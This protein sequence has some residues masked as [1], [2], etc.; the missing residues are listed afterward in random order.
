MQTLNNK[1]LLQKFFENINNDTYT[2]YIEIYIL[3]SHYNDS[4]NNVN[5]RENTLIKRNLDNDTF[6]QFMDKFKSNTSCKLFSKSTVKI[7][8]DNMI[9]N[10]S[11]SKSS[12][13]NNNVQEEI[14]Y[15]YDIQ[16]VQFLHFHDFTCIC[17]AYKKI[18]LPP[19]M[20]PSTNK[21]NDILYTQ[22]FSTKI[23]NLL[24]LNFEITT[25][26]TNDKNNKFIY[27]NYNHDKHTDI[28]NTLELLYSN[29]I[30]LQ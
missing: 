26:D 20:F 3:P 30:N 28:S 24:Y 22:R 14:V 19:H 16:N 23:N 18:I 6:S 12:T 27:F 1:T 10:K 25:N 15:I 8:H 4:N 13:S 9:L 11:S 7:Y 29:I 17:T 21:I 5:T 2:N